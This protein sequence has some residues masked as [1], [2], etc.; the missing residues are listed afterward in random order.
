MEEIDER[1]KDLRFNLTEEMNN[2]MI[3]LIV[4][5]QKQGHLIALV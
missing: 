1:V 3:E 5:K 2:T 4:V